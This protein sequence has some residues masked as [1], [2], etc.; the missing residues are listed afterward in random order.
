MSPSAGPPQS[1]QDAESGD[2]LNPVL[3]A[4]TALVVLLVAIVLVAATTL[5][6][7]EPAASAGEKAA[8]QSSKLPASYTVR[9]GDSYGSIA[10]K[11]GIK[12]DDLERLN[13]YV[14]PSTIRPGQRLKLRAA[15]PK[16]K[17]RGPIFHKVRKGDTFGSIAFRWG[18]T[19]PRLKE[20]N[21]KLKE[22]ALQPGDRLRLRK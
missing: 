15:P 21:P 11:I 19:V 14:N 3:L 16:V 1:D 2:R 17:K 4:A 6:D 8:R 5:T 7:A 22:T 18:R 13:P 9:K 10:R 20:L 12:V